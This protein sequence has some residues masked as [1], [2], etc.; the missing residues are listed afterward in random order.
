MVEVFDPASTQVCTEE[1]VE[2]HNKSMMNDSCKDEIPIHLLSSEGSE[3][4]QRR[5]GDS[6]CPETSGRTENT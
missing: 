2:Y 3:V 5:R 6:D 4:V 1:K